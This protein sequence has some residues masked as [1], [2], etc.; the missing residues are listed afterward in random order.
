MSWEAWLTVAVVLGML[1]ALARNWAPADMVVWFCLTVIVLVQTVTGSPLLPSAASAVSGMGNAG[2]MT[3]GVLFIV[4]EGLSRTG[5]TSFLSDPLLNLR[6]TRLGLRL[7]LLFTV[8]ASSAFLNNT[9]IVAMFL[10]VVHDIAKRSGTPPSKLFLP[11]CHA[12]TLGGV[13]TL[14]GT[15]TNLVVDGMMQ[16]AGLPGLGLFELSWVGVPIATIGVLYLLWAGPKLLRDRRPPVSTTTDP[17]EYSVAMRVEPAGGLVG[18]TIEDAGL[19]HLPGLFLAEVQRADE[20]LPAVGPHERLEA[21]DL[22]VFVGVVDSVVDLRRIRGLAPAEDAALGLK[23]QPGRCLIEAVVSSRCP[24]L[25]STIRDSDFRSVYDAAVLAVARSGERIR[26]KMGDI[27]LRTGDT[28]LLE[29]HPEFARR[30]RHSAHFFL[31]SSVENS[32]L[33]RRNKATFAMIVLALMIAAVATGRVELLPAALV[34]GA[35]MLV[36]RCCTATEARQA[37]DWSVLLVIAGALGV[38]SALESSGAAAAIAGKLVDLA[39]GSPWGVLFAI[40]L[41]TLLCT[42]LVTNNAA[43]ALMFPIAL[44]SA[45]ALPQPISPYPLVIAV[46]VAASCGFATPFGY[47]TN[48]MVAG[49]G[50]YKFSDYLR[51]GTPLDLLAMAIA[52]ALIPLVWPF[53]P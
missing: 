17:R 36:G 24:L 12:A 46:M 18:K 1:T 8:M 53:A 20:V 49:P 6:K 31:V 7:P 9:A 27:V 5:G 16:K 42:E 50:G 45:A 37:I 48:L 39:G 44:S 26:S 28:L 33:P 34:A 19:R 21:D 25:G 2:L 29:A 47:Q 41:A 23:E 11:M 14:I 43:A 35:V 52:V 13:C 30:H 51:L 22:L 40:Y 15:S 4:V 38:A 3:I 10:P 32:H